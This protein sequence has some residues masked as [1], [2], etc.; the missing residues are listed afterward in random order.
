VEEERRRETKEDKK[1]GPDIF[2]RE[3]TPLTAAHGI[4]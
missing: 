2:K 1:L 4:V 3:L